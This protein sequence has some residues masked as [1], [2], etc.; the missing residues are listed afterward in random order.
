MPMGII[1]I[2]MSLYG[3]SRHVSVAGV[4]WQ[5]AMPS[6]VELVVSIWFVWMVSRPGFATRPLPTKHAALQAWRFITMTVGLLVV[7]IGWITLRESPIS[8]GNFMFFGVLAAA[9]L[10]FLSRC[11]PSRGVR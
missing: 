11:F 10:I 9:F 4:D 1:G 3:M 2:V 8:A 5:R 7:W 6:I